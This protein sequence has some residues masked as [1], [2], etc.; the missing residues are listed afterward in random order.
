[1]QRQAKQSQDKDACQ[2]KKKP[3]Q[4]LS[5]KSSCNSLSKIVWCCQFYKVYWSSLDNPQPSAKQVHQQSQGQAKPIQVAP[6]SKLKEKTFPSLNQTGESS[7]LS[8]NLGCC[9][10]ILWYRGERVNFRDMFRGPHTSVLEDDLPLLCFMPVPSH[11]KTRCVP[12]VPR[13]VV[14]FC[15]K[16]F[17][18]ASSTK[19]MGHLLTTPNHQPNKSSSKAKD[20]PSQPKQ[21]PGPNLKRKPSPV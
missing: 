21:P 18:A 9:P 5:T 2:V 19:S 17:G 14:T 6:R 4:L 13:A 20:R 3:S 8:L 16:E 12:H 11:I 7:S 1:M 10:M 15:S